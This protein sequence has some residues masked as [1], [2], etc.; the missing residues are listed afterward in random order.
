MSYIKSVL[1]KQVESDLLKPV[2]VFDGSEHGGKIVKINLDD[3]A[4]NEK[5]LAELGI[6]SNGIF[7]YEVKKYDP[8]QEEG[9]FHVKTNKNKIDVK[10]K[11]SWTI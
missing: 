8:N 10:F 9:V 3:E 2:I 4:M 6:N 11:Y 1:Y 5:T 7:K